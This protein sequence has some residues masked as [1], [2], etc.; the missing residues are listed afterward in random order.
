MRDEEEKERVRLGRGSK[1][2]KIEAGAE[3]AKQRRLTGV[4][5][6][7]Q[8]PGGGEGR[9][10][11]PAA[12]CPGP[13]GA[14][15]P[16][17]AETVQ[18]VTE[19]SEGKTTSAPFS[20]KGGFAEVARWLSSRLDNFLFERCRAKP[21]GRVFPLP[22][23]NLVLTA[24]F[25]TEP[26]LVIECL[27]LLTASL[28]SLNGEGTFGDNKV[29][30]FQRKIL[31]HLLDHCKRVSSW[32]TVQAPGDWESFFQTKSIDY[33]GEEVLTAQPI[34]WE[35][36]APALP[37]EVGS[38]ELSQV[39]EEGCLHYV[40]NFTDFLVP[41][42]DQIY[43]KPPKVHVPSQSWPGVVE[44]LL[45]LGICKLIE[46]NEVHH[47]RGQPLLN[48]LFGVSKH[49]FS[50]AFEVRRLIMNLIPLN[51][52]CRALSGDV[53]TLPS[54]ANMSALHLM[55]HEDLLISSEDVRCFFY[56]FRVPAQWHPFLAF[57]RMVPERFCGGRQGKY[58]LCSTVL[59]MGFKNSE[60]IAQHIHRV[61]TRRALRGSQVLLG[62]EAEIRKD[63]SFPSGS[64]FYRIYLDN[65]DELRKVNKALAETIEGKVSAL[66]LGLRE[67][68]LK[69]SIP[70]H[71][72]KSVAQQ[73]VAEVQGAI[74]DGS[75][76]EVYPKPEKVVK[77]CQ[78]ACLLL[79]EGSC[80][81]RQ[82]QV[83]GGGFVYLAMFRRPLLGSLNSIWNFI[84][85][86]D[87]M[88]PFI[89]QE[90]PAAV[91]L[92]VAR[93]IGLSPL[94]MVNL[95]S[96]LSTCVT[97]SD[98]SEYGG[99]VTFSRGLTETGCCAAQCPVRGDIVEPLEVNGV[100]TIGL[101]D[102][103]SALRVAV[104]SLGWN[105]VGHISVETDPA[106]RRVVESR[107]PS[108]KFVAD[109]QIVDDDLVQSWAG[110]YSQVSLV[111]IGSGA[112]CQGVSG[113][114]AQRK[115][116]LRDERSCLFLHIPRIRELVKRRFPWAR[117]AT[118]SENV[119][120]MDEA[121]RR[122]MTEAFESTPWLIDAKDFSLARRPRLYWFDWE[123]LPQ[124]SVELQVE[125]NNGPSALHRVRVQTKVEQA[126][127]LT[128]GWRMKG[129]DAL[130]TFTTS[131][132][133]D[134]E[135]HRPAGKS[136]CQA[137]ELERWQADKFR[138]PPYQ[139]R[140]HNCLVDRGGNYRVPNVQERECILGFP[141]DYTMQALKKA[142]QGTVLHEDSRLTM[143][144]NSWSVTVVAWVLNHLGH[145]L[146]FHEL[147]NPQEI[148]ERTSPG[149][150]V[151]L[152]TY[153]L[154]PPMQ[155]QRAPQVNYLEGK[156]IKKLTC[157]VSLKGEDLL[158]QSQTEDVVRYHRLRASV[159]AR[160]WK[161]RVAASWQWSADREHINVL[162]M[163]AVLNALRWRLER[164]GQ[165]Q[166]KFVHM[167]DSLVC[168]HSLTRGRSSSRKLR[169][170][171]LRINSLLLAT[172]A[173]VV[174]AYVHTGQNP[175]D[176]PSRHP[177]KRKWTH[178]KTSP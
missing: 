125:E 21:M 170:T 116:A 147:R 118:L 134:Y 28:N 71:P 73:R 47:V 176:A 169:R 127:Y 94:A 107:F 160:L 136:S 126:R 80:T 26:P 142:Q 173:Q 3:R 98:A 65:Y 151:N 97:A 14:A 123:L 140:D 133:R 129:S 5:D 27:V 36:I 157:L 121:D 43:T 104:D 175:A 128:P 141:K 38:V 31:C 50:G 75:R 132:C 93:F 41:E 23:S 108:T 91:K 99:G 174:W 68:Y 12:F 52:I 2:R 22:T 172:G 106:A 74:V 103:I 64:H 164:K 11:L 113:L 29:S 88:P 110:E 16:V 163:R 117:V 84:V 60:S 49:E 40:Q 30:P 33:K 77:Y 63:R 70:R 161:W 10:D 168:L 42:E 89:K 153:L 177:R 154:R 96:D 54:W 171:L 17:G 69:T 155:Q 13:D 7:I 178:A 167:V 18:A 83:V 87:G 165:T 109:V 4:E 53:S 55:P 15:T 35:N 37:K 156:L 149:C 78:L 90:M 101:F 139:Y 39:V 6:F 95:R 72:K 51:R 56:I 66:S 67:E 148:V 8:S 137:H 145:V 152:Q 120:S 162:E 81:Q 131:R 34:Q 138:Y 105:V 1:E 32:E 20:L 135:G 48:G 166:I 25:P 130:P 115:G 58:Y 146:G 124:D 19:L 61:V 159:P 150:P 9:Q 144:G 82:A 59:P 76:G 92:E 112:P 122:L 79:Q 46:E 57:N 62:S 119:S 111:L 143:L 102:G 24:A 100:L 114:N 85:S 158:L 44:G 45:S 86:F